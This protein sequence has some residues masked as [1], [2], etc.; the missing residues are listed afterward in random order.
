MV[1]Q[2]SGLSGS[3]NDV[4]CADFRACNSVE[5][6]P[7]GASHCKFDTCG[8]G[9]RLSAVA[10]SM[11][12]RLVHL[13][14]DFGIQVACSEFSEVSE[15]CMVEDGF[16]DLVCGQAESCDTGSCHSLKVYG[17]RNQL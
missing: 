12:Y 10:G 1:C 13:D 9:S 8:S 16:L 14:Q 4:A 6:D 2:S 17:V 5:F 15:D 11:Y 7:H 3:D